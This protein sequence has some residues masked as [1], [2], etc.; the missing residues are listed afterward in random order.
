MSDEKAP[1][2]PKSDKQRITVDLPKDLK[3]AYANI[4][5]ISH[6]PG[7]VMLDFAQV[8][9]RTPRGSIVSRVILGPM[10]AKILHAALAQNIANYERQFGEIRIPQQRPNL[11][12]D[13]FRFPD[14]GAGDDD[15]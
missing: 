6:T 11:A 5:F 7:E 12:E 14:E 3:P 4:V 15:E 1:E 2:Q 9:P 13:F 8:L 10:Q